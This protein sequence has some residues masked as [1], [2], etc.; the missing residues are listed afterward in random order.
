MFANGLVAFC[1]FAGARLAGGGGDARGGGGGDARGGGGGDAFA[2]LKVVATTR[3][4]IERVQGGVALDCRKAMALTVA[5]AV[6]VPVDRMLGEASEVGSTQS[7]HL[8][9]TVSKLKT[10]RNVVPYASSAAVV[11]AAVSVLFPLIMASL[12]PVLVWFLGVTRQPWLVV[13]VPN[14]KCVKYSS[15]VVPVVV[16]G[17]G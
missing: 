10:R 12:K 16:D 13:P 7:E 9:V 8:S 15:L 1:V 2:S 6:Y 5:T 4:R 3:F 14:M 17:A 11:D